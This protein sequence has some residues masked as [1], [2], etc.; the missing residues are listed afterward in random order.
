MTAQNNLYKFAKSIL[1]NTGLIVNSVKDIHQGVNIYHVDFEEDNMNNIESFKVKCE[2][3]G[4]SMQTYNIPKK[5]LGRKLENFTHEGDC[6]VEV[7]KE[8]IKNKPLN[9]QFMECEI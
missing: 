7:A 2:H 1:K 3:C 4:A 8:V 9:C 5:N 6:I